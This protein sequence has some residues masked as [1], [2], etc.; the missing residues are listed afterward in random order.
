MK[1]RDENDYIPTRG[2]WVLALLAL[3]IMVGAI[4][5]EHFWR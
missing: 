1:W 3:A 4:L 5:L 2:D